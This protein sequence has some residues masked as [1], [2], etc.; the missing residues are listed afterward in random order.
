MDKGYPTGDNLA[1][2]QEKG[3]QLMGEVSP[4]KEDGRFTADEFDLDFEAKTAICPAGCTSSS[5]RVFESGKHQG[6]VEIRFGSSCQDC[7]L[8]AQCT[9]AKA[10]RKLRL[11]RH[12]PLLK[13][14][15]QEAQTAAFQHAMKRRPPIEG[16]L[17]E[18]V[19]A[20]G[21]RKTRYRGLEKTHLQHLMQGAAVNLKRVIKRLTLPERTP[22]QAQATA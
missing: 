17:S 8:K 2:S 6:A 22:Q 21:L 15:R 20:H 14:R 11:H 1:D 13:A 16:T 3:I 5:W 12:Y 9:Q 10:G 4:L 7:P 18:M 19:R